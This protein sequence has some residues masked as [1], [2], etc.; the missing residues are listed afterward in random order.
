MNVTV[1][2][3]GHTVTERTPNTCARWLSAAGVSAEQVASDLASRTSVGR[4]VTAAEVAAVVVFLAS[5]GSV[6]T[7]GEAVVGCGGQLGPIY[8]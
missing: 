1:V 2:H 4:L 6:A 5:P 7:T 8:Y 3:P